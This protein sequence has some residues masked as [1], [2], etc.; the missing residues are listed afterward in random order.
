MIPVNVRGVQRSFSG[1]NVLNGVDLQIRR[2]EFVALLGKS[3]S[4]KS[5]LLRILAGLDRP[6]GGIADVSG[7]AAI[8]FQEA[9]LLPWEKVSRNVG[10]GLTRKQ[11]NERVRDALDEVGLSH[12]ID[13]WPATLSGGEAQRAALARALVREPAVLLLDEPFGALDAL[14]RIA[15]HDLVLELF[16][17]HNPAVFMV[18][19]DIDEAIKL[20]DRVLVLDRGRV[21]RDV[22]IARDKN[23]SI[24]P[25]AHASIR[26]ELLLALGVTESTGRRRPAHNALAG[27]P[28]PHIQMKSGVN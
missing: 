26:D 28:A 20:S 1:V 25:T 11:A 16:E 15:M 5:T 7:S 19:H 27:E 21:D 10:M 22:R 24:A 9:R 18:T 6:D 3:G 12:R 4:G 13:A 17:R 2:G 8:V 14:T 23:G